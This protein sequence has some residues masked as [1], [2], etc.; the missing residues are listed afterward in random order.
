MVILPCTHLGICSG[1]L[2]QVFRS[3]CGVTSA[4]TGQQWWPF[5]TQQHPTA[6]SQRSREGTEMVLQPRDRQRSCSY[7][8]VWGDAMEAQV[9]DGMEHAQEQALLWPIVGRTATRSQDLL[10]WSGLLLST[11]TKSWVGRGT[12]R[13]CKC[14]P[15][16]MS[17]LRYF[18]L[19]I[20]LSAD[21]NKPILW[22]HTAVFQMDIFQ[23]TQIN[24]ESCIN[25][26]FRYLDDKAF[27]SSVYF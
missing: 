18:P 8:Q 16:P 21:G 19:D 17:S 6:P 7:G 2:R 9:G 4:K 14:P 15:E 1:N 23:S 25:L 11:A 12:C 5:P 26:T 20:V 24:K 13:T 22:G 27:S 3:S 10:H